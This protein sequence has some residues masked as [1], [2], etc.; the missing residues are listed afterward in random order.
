MVISTTYRR[1][2]NSKELARRD[3]FDLNSIEM[4][5]KHDKVN[6]YA[7]IV[8]CLVLKVLEAHPGFKEVRYMSCGDFT[9]GNY[10]FDGR[11]APLV[12]EYA[13]S[14]DSEKFKKG[15]TVIETKDSLID[16]KMKDLFDILKEIEDNDYS[17]ISVPE[18]DPREVY[19]NV[20]GE[21]LSFT[22]VRP[23]DSAPYFV[24]EFYHPKEKKTVAKKLENKT[25]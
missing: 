17:E 15:D 23:E 19:C 10:F 3:P 25:S 6:Y 22:Y 5:E 7:G 14:Q 8:S 20:V 24:F 1:E 13:A 9:L 16:T 12:T 2:F 11:E 21:I 18:I 4:L